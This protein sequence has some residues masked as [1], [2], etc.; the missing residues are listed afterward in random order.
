MHD[1]RRAVLDTIQQ[2]GQA[3]VASLAEALG[4]SPIAIR[5]HLTSAQADGLVCVTLQR[6]AVGRP[7]HVYT[8]SPRGEALYPNRSQLLA[9]RLLSEMKAALTPDQVSAIIDQMAEN[10]IA[11][12]GTQKVE[13]ALEARL[14]QLVE[15][16]GEEGFRAAIRREDDTTLV[17]ELN[18]PYV[19]I[20]QRHPEVCRIDRTLITSILGMEVD[21]RACVLEGDQTCVFRVSVAG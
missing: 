10:I 16:L 14:K 13:G 19:Q 21:R 4:I 1:T 7:K 5:H 2:Q 9:E 17:T 3:T 12:Y 11:R 15:I 18:C 8:L 6:Q 20:G